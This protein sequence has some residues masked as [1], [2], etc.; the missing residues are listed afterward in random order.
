MKYIEIKFWQIIQYI[1]RKNYGADCL[2]YE[3]ECL[4]CQAKKVIKFLDRHIELI[5][6]YD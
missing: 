4:S 5:S 2:D 3:E 1:L 6:W